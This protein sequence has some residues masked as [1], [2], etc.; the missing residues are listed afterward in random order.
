MRGGGGVVGAYANLKFSM[1]MVYRG[2]DILVDIINSA[3][4]STIHAYAHSYLCFYIVI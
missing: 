2:T 3:I 4:S 1:R